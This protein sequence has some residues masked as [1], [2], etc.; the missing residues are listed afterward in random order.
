MWVQQQQMGKWKQFRRVILYGWR[1]N[2]QAAIGL[3]ELYRFHSTKVIAKRAVYQQKR[4]LRN[5][6]DWVQARKVRKIKHFCLGVLFFFFSVREPKPYRFICSMT[7]NRSTECH[8][9]Y[10]VCHQFTKLK[11]SHRTGPVPA[12]SNE[13][14]KKRKKR[15]EC[16]SSHT[17]KCEYL[18]HPHQTE[19]LIS[20]EFHHIRNFIRMEKSEK[21]IKNKK[22]SQF[23]FNL[24]MYSGCC[25]DIKQFFK[26]CQ[27]RKQTFSKKKYWNEF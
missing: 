8:A 12:K 9:I 14:R 3:T 18:K 13:R 15:G 5:M 19:W 16:K 11:C 21:E 22:K 20:Y 10:V 17:L 2:K 7:S 23:P 24:C 26:M 6:T 4:V 27:R 25:S 1:R